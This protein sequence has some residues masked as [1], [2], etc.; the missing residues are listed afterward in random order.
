MATET[1]ADLA[2]ETIA[3][4]EQAGKHPLELAPKARA[5]DNASTPTTKADAS[6]EKLPAEQRSAATA[7][8]NIY[9]KI[10]FQSSREDQGGGARCYGTSSTKLTG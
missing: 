10:L 4:R 7:N 3:Q 9:L 8:V 2:N 6:W 5:P 1:V